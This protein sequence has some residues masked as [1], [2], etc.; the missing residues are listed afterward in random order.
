MITS[1]VLLFHILPMV[2]MMSSD[3]S[4]LPVAS[5]SVGN[6]T[7]NNELV[8]FTARV[9]IVQHNNDRENFRQQ[10]FLADDGRVI[11]STLQ[12]KKISVATG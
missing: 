12:P 10:F 6:Q 4:S 8:H 2:E 9:T 7:V 3:P 1:L 11:R 5:Q